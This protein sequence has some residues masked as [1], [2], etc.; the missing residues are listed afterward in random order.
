MAVDPVTPDVQ[1]A[2]LIR[3]LRVLGAAV[4]ATLG[5]WLVGPGPGD[6]FGS[7]VAVFVVP[8]A[9]AIVSAVEK[10]FFGDLGDQIPGHRGVLR[11]P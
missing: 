3:L 4:V 9:T 6:L 8:A 5:T 10:T 2:A 7:Q 1:R 11:S